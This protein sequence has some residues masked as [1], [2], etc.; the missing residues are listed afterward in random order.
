MPRDRLTWIVVILAAVGLFASLFWQ[1]QEISRNHALAPTPAPT[2]ALTSAT[3][4]A[5]VTPPATAETAPT[6]PAN[7]VPEQ[8]GQLKTTV[9]D[10][11]FSNNQGGLTT[12]AL[13]NHK[14]ED[15]VPVRLGSNSAPAIGAIATNPIDWHDSGYALTTDQN[16]AT[17]TRDLGN[18]VTLTKTFSN[19]AAAG[20][21]DPYQIKLVVS[22]RNAGSVD[23]H[24]PGFFVSVGGADP[25]HRTDN[26]GV[27]AFSWYKDGKHASI[28][29]NW[30]NPSSILGL[31]P[32]SSGHDVYLEAAD[33]VIWTAVSSQYFATVL[34]SDGHDGNQV[35]AKRVTIPSEVK[36]G[37]VT[38]I[39]GAMGI[40]GFD[41]RPGENK[42]FAFTIY[43]GPKEY[44]RLK[45]IP[46][47]LVSLMNFGLFAPVSE[48]LLSAMNLI[49]SVVGNY[50]LSI[51]IITLVIRSLLWPIQNYST[52][53]MRRM[54]K[55]S[56]VMTELREKYKDD[57]Q[58]MNQE[59]MK[60][61]KEYGVNPFS[62]CIPMLIQ[63]PIF[64][65]FFSMLGSA[66]EL[67][68]SSF[69]WVR[70]LSQPDTV[71]HLFGLPINIL[72]M[73]M[74]GT[75]LWQMQI[76]PKTGD[77]SQQRIL[78]IMPVVFLFICYNYASALSLYY[79]VQTLFLIVQTYLTRKQF[80]TELTNTKPAPV[81]A[82]RKSLR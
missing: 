10:L 43:A 73:V 56:P 62:G 6:P 66:I 46:D 59:M 44:S 19:H 32:T 55:L 7:P 78:Y 74:A 38:G 29:V 72:P 5:T 8:E 24:N 23:Y 15:D 80:D 22:F 28:N 51:I 31:I 65:G 76:M 39:E 77:P 49:H 9:A 64:F 50:A 75:Q 45:N 14:A 35:W 4:S 1:Q 16:K 18:G 60:L 36:G 41:L 71:G 58:R 42:D 48:L 13:N 82:K 3:P 68:N 20:L 63:I 30:F 2:P 57:P 11:F 53:S 70:D 26:P 52:K 34:A 27:T 37:P 67:R 47:D 17:L 21:K 69:L 54:A 81:V 61:Y 25:I 40:P 79:T 33:H 12:L